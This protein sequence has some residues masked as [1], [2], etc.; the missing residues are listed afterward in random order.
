MTRCGVARQALPVLGLFLLLWLLLLGGAPEL[1][2]YYH[3]ADHGY[4][5]SVGQQL[6]L[7][8]RLFVDLFWHYGPLAA[9]TSAGG[10]ALHPSLLPET[11]ICSCG[12]ALTLTVLFAVARRLAGW[13]TA[14]GLV[15][16][17][18]LLLARFYKWYY[19]LFPTLTILFLLRSV[20]FTSR[21]RRYLP[22]GLCCGVAFLYRADLGIGCLGLAFGGVLLTQ[23]RRASVRDL[24]GSLGLVLVAFGVPV[25]V[26]LG[27]LLSYGGE[28]AVQAYIRSYLDSFVGTSQALSLPLPQPRLELLWHPQPETAAAFGYYVL[29]LIAGVGLLHTLCSFRGGRSPGT[30]HRLFGCVCL[31]ALGFFPQAL[32]RAGLPHFLQTLPLFSLMIACVLARLGAG[33]QPSLTW[34]RAGLGV[35]LAVLAGMVFLARAD[36]MADLSFTARPLHKLRGLARPH[37][38]KMVSDITRVGQFLREHTT[39][40]DHILQ[41]GVLGQ[42]VFFCGRPCAGNCTC[43]APGLLTTDY[44]QERH[45]EQIHRDDPK[46]VVFMEGFVFDGR[47]QTALPRIQPRV[48]EHIE[49]QYTE[50]VFRSGTLVVRARPLSAFCERSQVPASEPVRKGDGPRCR[51]G[52]E[53]AS[54]NGACPLF[55]QA[56]RQVRGA[57]VGKR[58]AGAA[59]ALRAAGDGQSPRG[60]SVSCRAS[61]SPAENGRWPGPCTRRSPSLAATENQTPAP[62][63]RLPSHSRGSSARR[64]GANRSRCRA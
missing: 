17:D 28:P 62:P 22:L 20:R 19:W 7:G 45:L 33:A 16:V 49:R 43:Y 51:N 4:Q 31:G 52:P 48:W 13:P 18:F 40:R 61:P 8:K 3:S 37:R 32:H 5:L 44:W 38:P 27:V 54:H 25:A 64:R 47:P 6:L 26:W 50:T 11:L 35:S 29:P 53:G 1:S 9:L 23:L 42:L 39:K 30:R 15:A 58:H 60:A 12:Y 24:V 63:G 57:S 14:L 59:D 34:R 36:G 10:L 56:L 41:F 2:F 21:A 55:A 46:Y